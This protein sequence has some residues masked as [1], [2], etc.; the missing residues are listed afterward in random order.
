MKRC[1]VKVFTASTGE[2]M[3]ILLI[4]DG[5]PAFWPNLYAVWKLRSA[6]L[7][8]KTISST[9]RSIGMATDWMAPRG[10]SFSDRL[11]H[12]IPLLFDEATNLADF[13]T[14]SARSQKD[15]LKRVRD[16]AG[17][18]NLQKIAAPRLEKVRPSHKATAEDPT[19]YLNAATAAT[20]MRNVANYAEWLYT[21]RTHPNYATDFDS[22]RQ[23]LAIDGLNYFRQQIPRVKATSDDDETLWALTVQHCQIIEAVVLPR[24][25]QN[26]WRH[27]FIRDR[28]YLVWRMFLE[29]GG[30]R[31]EIHNAKIGDFDLS[32]YRVTLRISKTIPRTVG[33]KPAT[34]ALVHE[35]IEQ[36]WQHLPKSARKAGY[37]ITSRDG[38]HLSARSINLIFEAIR[39]A[40]PDIPKWMTPHTMRRTWNEHL[41]QMIDA[42]TGD[43]KWTEEQE[44][45]VRN[46][47]MG[48][49]EGSK[50][51][52]KY[53]RR[54][55]RRKA[56][57]IS[58]KLF[59]GVEI[60][61]SV[62]RELGGEIDY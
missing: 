1:R 29:T 3:A 19:I 18:S 21:L 37:L 24:S 57:E 55:T 56:D 48:W 17:S 15:W 22:D 2:E 27:P 42:Q 28:N 34:S 6:G 36:H 58:Q 49:S 54:H 23:T 46:R 12:G 53:L 33:Y 4:D 51:A 60:I 45:K 9:L 44:Q 59:E 13:L 41:S 52:A 61:P 32:K 14:L 35:F 39:A 31:G 11:M 38:D 16:T 43:D 25:D 40:S 62:T 50:T 20:N 8:P 30:R 5:S 47:L 10:V 7:S 26:P